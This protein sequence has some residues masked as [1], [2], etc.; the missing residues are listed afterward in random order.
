MKDGFG[1]KI[2]YLRISVTDKCNLRCRYCMPAQGVGHIPHEELLTLEEL[3][4]IA[5]IMAGLGV[6]KV[7]LTGGE[8]LVR[9][10]LCRLIED[11]HRLPGISEIAMTTNGVLFGQ[12]AEVLKKAGLTGVNISLDTLVPE[13]F[14]RLTGKKELEKVLESIDAALEQGLKVKL[15][16]VP[17]RGFNEKELPAL[18][19]F[20]RDR[21]I[22]V[23]FIELMPI[24]C[25]RDFQGIA[26][27]EILKELEGIYG[28]AA[29]ASKT[30]LEAEEGGPACAGPAQYYSFPGF[31]GKIGFISPLSHK[32]CNGCNRVRLTCE[33]RLKLCLHHE[34]G[35]EL[36]PLLRQG[37]S[38]EAVRESIRNAILQ[39]PGEHAFGNRADM[40]DEEQRKMVQI[41]G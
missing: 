3:F 15:N 34:R 1:R 33:G 5:G 41:G 24:G 18:A 38:D 20:A 12:Q 39:K 6:R 40:Q 8:P 16:C 10:N 37:A 21:K 27:D 22:D 23:R 14:Q 19:A 29:E 30:A 31:C 36:K 2:E 26:S 28:G 17:V 11:I 13:S 4:R 35:L 9:K 32:F 25:G 7:R